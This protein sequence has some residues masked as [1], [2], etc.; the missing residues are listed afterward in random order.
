VNNDD[1]TISPIPALAVSAEGAG[2]E[3]PV[4]SC[5]ILILHEDFSAY[6]RAVEVCRGIMDRSGNET[7]FEIKCWNFLDLADSACA[8]HA[9][10][11]AGMADIILLSLRTTQSTAELDRWLDFF[12]TVRFK[13][14]GLL[15]V[16]N[17]AHGPA[18]A[19]DQL[20]MRFG[21]CAGRLG[22]DF[23][24]VQPGDAATELSIPLAIQPLRRPARG[25]SGTSRG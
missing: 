6:S 7:D 3:R 17:A 18:P 11:A 10:R 21:Q 13:V 15:A 12:F 23:I 5:Q 1:P 9:A 20:I 25:L 19:L 22:M 16:L 24:P 14:G 4:A 8:R 2:T